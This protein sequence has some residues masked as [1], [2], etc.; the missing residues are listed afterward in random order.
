VPDPSP[1]DL[2]TTLLLPLLSAPGAEDAWRVFLARY[3]PR[4]VDWASRC[5]VGRADAEQIASQVLLKLSCGRTLTSFDRERGR[6]RPWLRR[7]VQRATLDFQRE[8]KKTPGGIGRGGNSEDAFDALLDAASLDG[9]ADDLDARLSHDL[10]EAESAIE[11]VRTR[12][13]AAAPI[14]N[15]SWTN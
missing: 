9:L 13:C 8:L 15:R 6:F 5:G 1:L 12:I 4:I 3:W 14:A 7:V 11:R 2:R 10:R